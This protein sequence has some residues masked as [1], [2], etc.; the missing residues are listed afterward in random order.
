MSS[1]SSDNHANATSDEQKN[2]RKILD[3]VRESD[4]LISH[5]QTKNETNNAKKCNSNPKSNIAENSKT[6][7]L[8]NPTSLSY[9][10]NEY[11]KQISIQ[12]S[13]LDDEFFEGTLNAKDR[14]QSW[15]QVHKQRSYIPSLT[16][17]CK[18]NFYFSLNTRRNLDVLTFQTLSVCVLL[19][20]IR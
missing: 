13:D 17:I 1:S 5:K 2:L 11:K 8:N 15:S 16:A 12:S 14:R 4:V 10:S 19:N 7:N 3:S 6:K 9:L 18:L 20:A